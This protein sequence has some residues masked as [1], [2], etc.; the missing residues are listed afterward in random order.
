MTAVAA[1]AAAAA[2]WKCGRD[3]CLY[4]DANY[5]GGGMYTNTLQI[6]DLAKHGMNE[7]ISSVY[8][9]GSSIPTDHFV[10]LWKDTNFHG[11]MIA[12]LGRGTSIKDMGR[13]N[14]AASSV[15]TCF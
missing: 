11:M 8:Y 3:L 6:P 9:K 13:Y 10:C 15:N 7:K 12:R 14:D 5:K 4:V 1:P 2:P